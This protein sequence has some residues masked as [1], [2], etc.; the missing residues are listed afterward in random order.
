ML[1]DDYLEFPPATAA[2]LMTLGSTISFEV[3]GLFWGIWLFLRGGLYNCIRSLRERRFLLINSALT[4][5]A[6]FG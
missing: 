3:N 2:V 6:T 1:E 4:F 5:A